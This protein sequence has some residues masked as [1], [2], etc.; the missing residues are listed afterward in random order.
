[1]GNYCSLKTSKIKSN[2]VC[3]K[4]TGLDGDLDTSSEATGATPF[5]FPFCSRAVAGFCP[6]S[7]FSPASIMVT[8]MLAFDSI[9]SISPEE[10]GRPCAFRSSSVANDADDSRIIR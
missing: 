7:S 9:F 2:W 3:G 10:G 4:H 8:L 6:S 1:M 5:V